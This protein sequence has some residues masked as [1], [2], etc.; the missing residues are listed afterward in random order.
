MAAPTP[1]LIINPRKATFN[2]VAPMAPPVKAAC[3]TLV[4]AV[5][6][7]EAFLYKYIAAEA[8]LLLTVNDIKAAPSSLIAAA[9][10]VALAA[11]IVTLAAADK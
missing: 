5:T 8:N 2:V 1:V 3:N 9:A 4:V 6:A 10:L 11:S 7:N